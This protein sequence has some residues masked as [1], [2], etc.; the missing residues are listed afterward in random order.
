MLAASEHCEGSVISGKIVPRALAH[1][2]LRTNDVAAMIDWYGTVFEAEVVFNNGSLAFLTFDDE[3]H[4]IAIGKFADYAAPNPQSAGIDHVAFSYATISDLL[5]T[6]NRLKTHSI[7]PFFT[8]DHGPTTSFYYKDPDGNQIELQ[9]DN[10]A[11][12]AD[13]HAFFRSD[14]FAA[15]PLGVEIDPGTLLA[16]L[17]AGEPP[18]DLLS[19]GTRPPPLAD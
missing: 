13:S 12:L 9:V 6:Y 1:I 16:R 14:A 2:V 10:F 3:H 17:Q 7:V 19:S 18:Q 5:V 11:T 8:I 4:R 15:N